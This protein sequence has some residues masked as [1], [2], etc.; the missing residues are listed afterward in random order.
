MVGGRQVNDMYPQSLTVQYC[1]TFMVL[2]VR[3][4]QVYT[5]SLGYGDTLIFWLLVYRN[6]LLKSHLNFSKTL[7]KRINQRVFFSEWIR[8]SG[9]KLTNP[10]CHTDGRIHGNQVKVSVAMAP[11]CLNMQRFQF[12]MKMWATI[13]VMLAEDQTGMP[14]QTWGL[15]VRDTEP[16]F[17]KVKWNP[18]F[19]IS[20]GQRSSKPH[21]ESNLIWCPCSPRRCRDRRQ[22]PHSRWTTRSEKG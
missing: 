4:R 11:A 17:P 8:N 13:S 7:S 14:V 10:R 9:V 21:V 19:S 5:K 18:E 12:M 22:C 16:A 1:T 3:L 2:D 20:Q 15:K 6:L